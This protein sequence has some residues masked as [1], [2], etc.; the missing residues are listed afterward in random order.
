[1]I[2]T[3]ETVINININEEIFLYLTG[4]V[5][6]EKNLFPAMGYLFYIWEMMASFKNE[7]YNNIPIVFEDVNFIRAT[8][9]TQ[10]KEIELTLSIQEGNII[11]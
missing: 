5:I 10:Q 9:L 11:T 7:E 4:H 6:N 8:V 2:N 1:M 3:R